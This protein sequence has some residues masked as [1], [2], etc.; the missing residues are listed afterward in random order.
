[1]GNSY[2]VGIPIKTIEKMQLSEG[3]SVDVTISLPE[4]V[5]IGEVN[6]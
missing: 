4:I 6:F 2:F 5:R 1:M 3:D